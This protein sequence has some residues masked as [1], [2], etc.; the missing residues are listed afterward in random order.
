M[1]RILEPELM[2]DED[3]VI[4]YAQ[5]DFDLPHTDFIQ[6]LTAFIDNPEFSGAALDLG[7]GPGDISCRFAGVFPL[8]KV[9]A[10]DGSQAMLDHAKSALPADFTQR[11]NFITGYLPD[12]TL[13]QSG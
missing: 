3:Q 2:E 11:I 8:S 4:A 1:N 5:A 10:V 7:C 9:H 6:R 12:V 13:P